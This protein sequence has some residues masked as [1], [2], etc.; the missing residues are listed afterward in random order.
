MP[1]PVTLT[2]RSRPALTAAA[3]LALAVLG[4]CS[5]QSPV[6]TDAPYL[7]ADGV[8]AAL[9]AVQARNLVVVAQ[10]KGATGVLSGFIVNT[11]DDTLS[12]TFLTRADS[13]AGKLDGPTVELGPRQQDRIRGVQ[14]AEVPVAPGALTEI[15][16]KSSAGQT[17]VTV[18]VL[19]PDG[20]YATITATPMSTATPTTSTTVGPAVETT[21]TA[22][23]AAPTTSP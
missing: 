11:G 22:A 2:L 23:T 3:V 5:T 9:G 21:G 7:P 16:L 18:P 10:S 14:F 6:Q 4:A 13:E 19:L 1:R 15:V 20:Y 12:V 17:Y 8:P